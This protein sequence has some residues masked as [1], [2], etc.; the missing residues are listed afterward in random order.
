[1]RI[2]ST[3]M[4]ETSVV[5]GSP[6]GLLPSKELDP[7]I[8]SSVPIFNRPA[9][10]LAL[11]ISFMVTIIFGHHSH[12]PVLTG[13]HSVLITSVPQPG[14]LMGLLRF[15][16]LHPSHRRAQDRMGRL[17]PVSRFGGYSSQ[18][19]NFL[20]KVADNPPTGMHD[21]RLRFSLYW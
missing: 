9:D 21:R 15:A 7:Q 2:R 16:I 19:S 13:A 12:P 1:M 5:E 8:Y 6:A 18:S 4:P 14:V 20:L 3:D 10:L 11:V 17:I